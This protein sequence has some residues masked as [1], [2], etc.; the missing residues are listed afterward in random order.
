MAPILRFSDERRESAIT[1]VFCCGRA[2]YMPHMLRS[3]PISP[4]P[5]SPFP[6][7]PIPSPLSAPRSHRARIIAYPQVST[8][9]WYISMVPRPVPITFSLPHTFIRSNRISSSLS[10]LLFTRFPFLTP[11][12]PLHQPRIPSLTRMAFFAQPPRT[13]PLFPRK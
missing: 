13:S 2:A 7:L 12:F 6:P 4:L 10:L 11:D 5:H 1:P 9:F 3:I 8:L